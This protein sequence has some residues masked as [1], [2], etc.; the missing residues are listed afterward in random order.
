VHASLLAY[1]DAS[2]SA[3]F[4]EPAHL[5]A[6]IE[7]WQHGDFTIYSLSPPL[8]RLWAAVPALLAHAHSP[9][10]TR[11]IPRPI[12]ERH[13]LYADDFLAANSSRFEFLL[14]VAR[15]GMIPISCF[16]GWVVYIWAR[17]LYGPRAGAAAC[18]MYCL[19]PSILAHGCLVTTDV[20]TAAAM[21]AACWLWWRYCRRPSWPGWALVCVAVVAAHLCKFTAVLLWPMLLAMAIPFALR[22]PRREIGKF[23]AAWLVLAVASLLIINA[24]YGFSGTFGGLGSLKFQSAFMQ[25]IQHRLPAGFPSPVPRLILE[26]FDAQKFDTELGYQGFLFGEIYSKSRWYYYPVALACKLPVS[27]MLLLAAAAVSTIVRRKTADPSGKTAEL[28]L[29]LAVAVFAAGVALLGDVNIGTRYLLPAFPLVFILVARLWAIDWRFLLPRA[30]F[31][32]WLRDLLL[33]GLALEMLWVCPHFISFVNFA[34]GG[35]SNGWRLLSN[36]D[37]DWGQGLLDLRKWM[38]DNHV[39][40]V[41]FIYFGYVDPKVYGIQYSSTESKP[42]FATSTYFLNGLNGKVLVAPG[43]HQWW[44]MSYYRQLQVRPRTATA[45]PT[46]FIYRNADVDAAAATA[47]LLNSSGP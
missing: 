40:T 21:L 34:F 14:F 33:A 15:L 20:G 17:D 7:Y 43:A 3:T 19:N 37:F 28:S 1:F 9:P 41:T 25:T 30:V 47:S 44:Q 22:R 24:L 2:N 35:P 10:T 5:A 23:S 27:M 26:G 16:A 39:P 38:N 11:E 13:W 45:G 31:L 8:L 46:I 29:L 36:S 4:D 6:G 32:P 18:A 42:Y 12:V